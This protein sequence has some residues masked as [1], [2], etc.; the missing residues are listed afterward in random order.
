[1]PFVYFEFLEDSFGRDAS[2]LHIGA[3][4]LAPRC[5]ILLVLVNFLKLHLF[6]SGACAVVDSGHRFTV[7]IL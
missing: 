6:P 7:R 3:F 5:L 1:M 4:E 2:H